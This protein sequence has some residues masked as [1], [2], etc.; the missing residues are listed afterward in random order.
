[1]SLC[2]SACPAFQ[3]DHTPNY[4]HPCELQF[5]HGG[6]HVYP[7]VRIAAIV[8]E[9]DEWKQ[10]FNEEHEI[11][12]RLIGEAQNARAQL[13]EARELLNTANAWTHG[14]AQLIPWLNRLRIWE[15][16]VEK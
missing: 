10:Q 11:T 2:K 16:K 1:M 7:C 14:D 13:A 12:V 4:Y 8:K 15:A 6:A 9:R 5:G 3:S